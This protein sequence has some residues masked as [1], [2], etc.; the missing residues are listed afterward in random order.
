MI[1]FFYIM[2]IKMLLPFQA[3]E[4]YSFTASKFI[5]GKNLATREN[6]NISIS[7][8]SDVKIRINSYNYKS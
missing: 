4:V 2:L 3:T 1:F 6:K 8:Y 7:M 5:Y